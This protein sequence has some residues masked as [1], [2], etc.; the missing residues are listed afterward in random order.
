MKSSFVLLSCILLL[1]ATEAQTPASKPLSNCTVQGQIIQQPGGQPLRKARVTLS[2]TSEGQRDSADLVAITDADGHFIIEDVRPGTYRVGY[3]RSGFVDAEKRHHCNR[4]LLSLEAGQ[5]VKDLLFHMAPAAVI[6]GKVTDIDGDP[7]PNVSVFVLAPDFWQTRNPIPGGGGVTNDLGEFRISDL[8]PNRYTIVA[9]PHSRLAQPARP[10]KNIDKNG[11]VYV[12]TYYP[13]TSERSH[14]IALD[15]HSGDEV[16]IN[17]TLG[18]AQLFHVRGQVTNL[19]VEA[20]DG[21]NIMLRPLDEGLTRNVSPWPVDNE[22]KFDISGA[23]PGSYSILLTFGSYQHPSMMRGDQTVQVTSADVE[24]LRISP[25]PNVQV[26]GR[27]RLDN[28]EKID[29]SQTQVHLYSSLQDKFWSGGAV[30]VSGEALW[31]DDRPA[32]AEVSKDGSFEIKGVPPDTYRLSVWSLDTVLETAFVKTV[33]LGA[34]DVTDSGFSVAGA[35]YSLDVVVGT[36]GASVEGFVTDSKDRPASDVYVVIAP[37]ADGSRRRDL[38]R[39]TATDYR[40]HFSLSGLNPREFLL[41]ATDE[42][43]DQTDFMDPEFIH[44]HESLS[45]SVQLKEGEHQSILL[46]LAPPSD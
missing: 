40:G 2:A 32:H 13:G 35:S 22:G 15:V 9:D 25:V 30:D 38:Y 8:A 4:M 24:G 3:D 46:K 5:E 16:P 39:I 10:A 33:K 18:T 42:D 43:P 26:H 19:P 34:R 6:T 41:F 29:W 36:H 14:A 23:F 37:S 21:A 45:K 20:R 12:A 11:L 27:L 28:G 17:I 31:W 44:A 1:S 7:A